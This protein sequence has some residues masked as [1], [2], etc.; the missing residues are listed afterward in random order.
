MRPMDKILIW[1]QMF[2]DDGS[3]SQGIRIAAEV[4]DD[5]REAEKIGIKLLQDTN[6]TEGFLLLWGAGD[7][8]YGSLRLI[9]SSSQESDSLAS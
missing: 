1:A 2:F 6:R 7:I 4:Y 5:D 9:S 3:V 8:R